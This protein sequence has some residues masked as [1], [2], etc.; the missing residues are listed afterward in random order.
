VRAPQEEMK[1][2]TFSSLGVPGVLAAFLLLVASQVVS[3]DFYGIRRSVG[4][5]RSTPTYFRRR[6]YMPGA[7][8]QPLVVRPIW[9]A[10][11]PAVTGKAVR[12]IVTST[13]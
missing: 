2:Q 11:K 8:R 9:I 12:V 5:A 1:S 7:T 6:T 13:K 4:C 10:A 3:V